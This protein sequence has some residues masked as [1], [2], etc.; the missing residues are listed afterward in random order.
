VNDAR[1]LDAFRRDYFRQHTR[2]C[3]EDA[4]SMGLPIVSFSDDSQ[5]GLADR[6]A[7]HSS[8]VEALVSVLPD[9]PTSDDSLDVFAMSCLSRAT[10]RNLP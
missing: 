4:A 5:A 3:P 7:F 9:D 8:A 2:L 1:E 10:S 6:R